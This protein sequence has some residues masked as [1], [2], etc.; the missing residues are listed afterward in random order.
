VDAAGCRPEAAGGPS[1]PVR[2]CPDRKVR[3]FHGLPRAAGAGA[4]RRRGDRP[5]ASGTAGGRPDRPRSWRCV[6]GG[7]GN[8]GSASRSSGRGAWR[9]RR[10][11]DGGRTHS[12]GRTWRGRRARGKLG[13]RRERERRRCGVSRRCRVPRRSGDAG[14]LGDGPPWTQR[15]PRVSRPPRISR[16]SPRISRP[17]ISRPPWKGRVR[18]HRRRPLVRVGSL[19]VGPGMVVGSVAVVLAVVRVR[20]VARGRGVTAARLRP[21]TTCVLVLL[22]ARAGVLPLRSELLRVVG[23]RAAAGRVGHGVTRGR[24]Q[25]RR[26]IYLPHVLQPPRTGAAPPGAR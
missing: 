12:G 21:A 26:E 8:D 18:C 23:T 2:P 11:P 15:P 24:I 22:P 14:T 1:R 10:A 3:A 17:Q 25:R 4:D 16:R 19:G 13:T 9:A 6:E 7:L 5:R 20:R